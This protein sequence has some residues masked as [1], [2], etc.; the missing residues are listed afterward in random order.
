MVGE[1]L[2]KA[3]E[4]AGKSQEQLAFDAEIDRSYLSQLENNRKSPTLETL[5][6]LCEALGIRASE[7]IARVEQGQ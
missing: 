3:R 5:F 6:R 2:K 1:E 7:L 4:S